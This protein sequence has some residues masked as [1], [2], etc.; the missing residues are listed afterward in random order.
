MLRPGRGSG[1]LAA[2]RGRCGRSSAGGIQEITGADPSSWA[3]I[4]GRCGDLSAGRVREIT[5]AA[6]SSW[7]RIR[8]RGGRPWPLREIQRRQGLG[9]HRSR[10][11]VLGADPAPWRPSAAVGEI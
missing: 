6:A 11:F 8:G 4:R 5:G 7:A 2:V 3:R 1:A 9:D 10:S